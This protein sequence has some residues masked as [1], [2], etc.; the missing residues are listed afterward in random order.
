[1]PISLFVTLRTSK[2]GIAGWQGWLFA[3][4][5]LGF[6]VGGGAPLYCTPG[7]HVLCPCLHVNQLER[8]RECPVCGGDPHGED[9]K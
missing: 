2:A 7:F 8:E 4:G 5:M 6:W 9:R 1:M 3:E